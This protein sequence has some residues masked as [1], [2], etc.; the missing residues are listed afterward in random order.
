MSDLAVGLANDLGPRGLEMRFPVC[1]VSVLVRIEV[2]LGIRLVNLLAASKRAVRAFARVREN[3]FGS[4]RVQY[5]LTFGRC[6]R[7]QTQANLVALRGTNHRIR[8]P[9]IPA[10]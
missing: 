7:G 10:R 3:E 1:R 6:I 8:N 4:E 9:G 5:L 2:E